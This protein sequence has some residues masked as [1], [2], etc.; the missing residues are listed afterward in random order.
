MTCWVFVVREAN[1]PRSTSG[2]HGGGPK[3]KKGAVAWVNAACTASVENCAPASDN[4]VQA[5]R[6]R[7]RGPCSVTVY[8]P[9]K[10]SDEDHLRHQS[11]LCLPIGTAQLGDALRNTLRS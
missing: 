7:V 6:L 2:K 5:L 8:A 3:K 10:M 9:T 11:V 1:T 4:W